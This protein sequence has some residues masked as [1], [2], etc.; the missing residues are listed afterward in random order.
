MAYERYHRQ[1]RIFALLDRLN[2]RPWHW[3]L[4]AAC[5]ACADLLSG[6]TVHF[7]VL[8]LAP[9]LLA[10][11]YSG[12]RAGVGVALALPLARLV[13]GAVLWHGWLHAPAYVA[14]GARML[15]YSFI[16]VLTS[17]AASVRVLRGLLPICAH[18]K[19]IRSDSD[20]WESIEQYVERNSEALFSH[21]LCPDC[22]HVHYPDVV[23]RLNRLQ[24][25]TPA[26]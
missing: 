7:P 23:A 25:R 3:L 13:Y 16:A 8:Y 21:G 15:I 5:V 26:K 18:C 2:V 20:E 14:A 1:Q 24:T 9:V 12:W 4:L 6:P 10:A 17:F 11:W 22:L 19:R